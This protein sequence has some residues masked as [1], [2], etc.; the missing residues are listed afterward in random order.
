MNSSNSV[1]QNPGVQLIPI[2][3]SRAAATG[4]RVLACASFLPSSFPFPGALLLV[5]SLFSFPFSSSFLLF[6]SF[7]F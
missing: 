3:S 1:S 5:P 4:N 2:E 6:P 7:Y